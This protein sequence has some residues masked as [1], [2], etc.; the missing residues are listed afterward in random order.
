MDLNQLIQKIPKPILVVGVLV[1]SIILFIVNDPL[2]DECEIQAFVF[3]NKMKGILTR[4]KVNGKTQFPLMTYWRDRCKEG[5]SIG[6]CADYLDGLKTMTKELKLMSD[7][8]QV[9]YSQKK[10]DFSVYISHGLQ[11]MALVAWGEKPPDSVAERLGWLNLAHMQTFCYL[12]RTFLLIGGEENFLSLREKVYR[13][14][15]DNWP[16]KL[17]AENRL[18]EN[19]PRAYKTALNPSGTLGFEQIY[20][21]S[22]FSIRCDL[23]M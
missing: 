19:R 23:Y 9:E 14:F 11:I 3:D 6:S 2:R 5:N 7:K 10:E 12:K 18:P 17:D 21:R 8:C 4:A 13:E 16:E 15:P 20:Q 22:I 1:I